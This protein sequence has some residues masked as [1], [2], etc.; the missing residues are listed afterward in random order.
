[1][2]SSSSMV[3]SQKMEKEEEGYIEHKTYEQVNVP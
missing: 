2:S 1:M 3:G